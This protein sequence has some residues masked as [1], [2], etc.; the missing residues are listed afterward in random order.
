[1][2]R[3]QAAPIVLTDFEWKTW[4]LT[5]PLGKRLFCQAVFLPFPFRFGG[6]GE[7]LTNQFGDD[8]GLGLVG[9][10]GANT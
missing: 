4:S 2:P 7:L 6:F 5:V 1:M 9:F 8:L 10:C 3:T